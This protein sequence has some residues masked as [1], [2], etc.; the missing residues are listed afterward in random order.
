MIRKR[1]NQKEIPTQISALAELNA[2]H[3]KIQFT[4]EC[5]D[6]QLPF[7]DVLVILNEG[8]I[9]TDIYFKPTDTQMYLNFKSCHPKSFKVNIPFCLASR[10]VTI[11][12]D[13][14]QQEVRLNQLKGFLRQQGYPD[15][16]IRNGIT[17]AIDKGPITGEG[18]HT[19]D[20]NV[21]PLVTTFNP[22][23]T[24]VL[25][26]VRSCEKVL[27]KSERMNHILDN[28]KIINSK[29]Q[30]KNLKRI[31]TSSKFDS[32]ILEARVSKC[33]DKRCKTCPDLIQG[34][35]ITF[36]NGKHFEVKSNM[37]C[38]TEFVVY[39]LTCKNCGEFYVGKT[40][41]MLKQRM[42]VH[43]QQT[44][45]ANLRVLNV[46]KH[47]YSC[48]GG[49]FNIFP[50]YSVSNANDSMLEEKEKLF[51]RILQPSLNA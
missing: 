50:I 47:F 20:T 18:R 33:G 17:K 31:L 7:L 49:G 6:K 30:P 10:I 19:D 16:L 15:S 32:N 34:K 36:V 26:F 39:T 46:N 11:V 1:R 45:D 44:N 22:C 43:R 40:T 41:N 8:K 9:S 29:R 28:S 2:I 25:P 48:S 3:P 23:N 27:R 24:N 38:K 12:S 21:I 13:R 42:T 37:N 14:S 4:M 5:S 51:I 35:E